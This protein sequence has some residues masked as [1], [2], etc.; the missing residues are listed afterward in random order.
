M[1]KNIVIRFGIWLQAI[2][3]TVGNISVIIWWSI[4]SKRSGKQSSKADVQSWFLINLAMA[5]FLM[6]IYLMIIAIQDTIFQGTYF[7]HDVDWRSGITCQIA[8]AIS[9]LSSEVSVMMLVAMTAD[10]LNSIIFDLR[11]KRLNLRFARILCAI[12]W[13]IGFLVSFMPVFLPS[14]FFD[15]ESG[16]SFYGR[17]TVCLPFQLTSEQPA[18]WEYSVAVF[19]VFNGAA[20]FFIFVA[21]TAIFIKVQQSAKGVRNS[22][23]KSSSLG[24]R[25]VFVVMTDFL[26]WMPVIVIGIL[27]LAGSF[28]DSTGQ[29]YAW[30]AVFVLPVN[31]SINPIL[32]TFSTPQVVKKLKGIGTTKTQSKGLII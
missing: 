22:R 4:G 28:K 30:I 27:S 14:Y 13:V 18:G 25:V 31:S 17:S 15:Q 21:Y 9:T 23:S 16:F 29:V 20:I 19:I 11:A 10:R 8:G 3:A 26:C 32:Y 24:R 2:F 7:Q 6:G 1:L 12:V 5:D